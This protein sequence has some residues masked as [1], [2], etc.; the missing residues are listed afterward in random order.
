MNT[1]G[2]FPR[3]LYHYVLVLFSKIRSILQ[4]YLVSRKEE[5][6][7]ITWE[8]GDAGLQKWDD[9]LSVVYIHPAILY[10][11][12][13]PRN[14]M[15]GRNYLI[16]LHL[17]NSKEALSSSLTFSF[18]AISVWIP[19]LGKTSRFIFISLLK[20]E[21]FK[22]SIWISPVQ[23]SEVWNAPSSERFSLSF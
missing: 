14:W 13:S 22:N 15:L 6:I 17:L 18:I 4:I 3:L 21:V 9:I 5:E 12:G 8:A 23:K 1:P 11:H 20:F 2:V 19:F 10:Y 7:I 16:F